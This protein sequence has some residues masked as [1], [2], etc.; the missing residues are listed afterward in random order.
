MKKVIA[1]LMVIFLF[2][3]MFYGCGKGEVKDTTLSSVTTA[4][5]GTTANTTTPPV[6]HVKEYNKEEWNRQLD[7]LKYGEAPE[8]L[9]QI[10]KPSEEDVAFIREQEGDRYYLVSDPAQVWDK[11]FY[12]STYRCAYIGTFDIGD[13]ES[14]VYFK[15]LPCSNILSIISPSFAYYKKS[16][17]VT[18]ATPKEL[19]EYEEL[20]ALRYSEYLDF[21]NLASEIIYRDEYNEKEWD[22]QL[23]NLKYG[24]VPGYLKQIG[25]PSEEDVAFIREQV[26]DR[27]YLVSDPA[28]VWD[29]AYHESSYICLYMG[30]FDIG[31]GE[32]VVYFH[33][34]VGFD[35][36]DTIAPS[37]AYYKK[38]GKVIR[39]TPRELEEYRELFS[40]R[41]REY[42]DFSDV[43]AEMI[44]NG[45]YDEKEW[46]RQLDNLKYGEVPEYLK[47]IGVPSKEDMDA[48]YAKFPTR[49]FIIDP[50]QIWNKDFLVNGGTYLIYCGTFDLENGESV[51][52]FSDFLFPGE[53]MLVGDWGTRNIAYYKQSGELVYRAS[54]IEE[55]HDKRELIRLRVNEYLDFYDTVLE[56]VYNT[57]K[58]EELI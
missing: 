9:K 12:E 18:R 37:F 30:T 21:F 10:G 22:R 58:G 6:D 31:D 46:K 51:M 56:I 33:G 3:V 40:L 42:L 47:Q 44:Y 29:K 13:G 7:N 24:E 48:I 27:Y 41:C 49:Y 1:I 54:N 45:G 14:I 19:E 53:D 35:I 4:T 28:Q 16:G 8:Y 55:L 17:K 11:A 43:A 36:V 25:V 32:S 52:Y 26:G 15:G 5:T 50:R 34:T 2:T 20:F 39:A 57:N 38:S 23:Y